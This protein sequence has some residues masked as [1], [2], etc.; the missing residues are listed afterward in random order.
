MYRY[1]VSAQ[2]LLSLCNI[3]NTFIPVLHWLQVGAAVL[4]LYCRCMALG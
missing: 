4:P 1:T 2:M 3:S